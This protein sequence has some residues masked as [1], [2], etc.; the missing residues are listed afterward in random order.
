[1]T[2]VR[3]L[4]LFHMLVSVGSLEML[5]YCS[6]SRMLPAE[7]HSPSLQN[8]RVWRITKVQC[9]TGCVFTIVVLLPSAKSFSLFTICDDLFSLAQG[10][11]YYT[12][13]LRSFTPDLLVKP[14][15]NMQPVGPVPETK[16]GKFRFPDQMFH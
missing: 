3:N 4:F 14:K 15:V 1:M 10:Y 7:F 13:Q 2:F 11:Y 6:T 9:A 5:N 8:E 16:K 12:L